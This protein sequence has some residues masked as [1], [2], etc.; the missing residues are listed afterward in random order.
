MRKAL[1]TGITGQDGSYL[2][3]LLLD[4]GY[5]VHGIL[6]RSSVENTERIRHVMS[7]IKLHYGDLT[8]SLSVVRVLS[9]VQPNEIYNLAAQSH[10]HVSFTVPEYTGETDAL[11]T[12]RLLESVRVLG[13][14]KHVRIYQAGTSELFGNSPLSPQNETTPFAPAS[15]Y[16]AAKLYAHEL[17]R[18]YREAFGLFAVNGILFNHESERRGEQF[19]TRKI[20]RA[21][22]RI[23]EGLQETLA[24]G[25]LDSRRD[26]G[27]APDYVECMW[28]MLQ[29]DWP[30][31]YV[32]ATG[33]QH[34]VREFAEKA[35][36]ENGITLEW[37]GSG[38][39]ERGVDA[40]DGMTRVYVDQ[41]F[42][43]PDDV[44]SLL[45][46]PSKA[47]NELGWNS[48]KTSFDT[49]VSVMARHDRA[50]ARKERRDYRHDG[51]RI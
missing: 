23:A 22:G 9:E 15:P 14:E 40:A 24:L 34:S 51:K 18:I 38:A 2:S 30:S 47:V 1:I 7:E 12:L 41:A 31:D 45:G 39:H 50:L 37:E 20:T 4:K 36:A 3:E 33:V 10:V 26:W 48:E 16:A 11:G 46:D 28:R 32:V 19:V 13:M 44:D 49:L 5:E 21:A 42:F 29:N 43:R 8:D 35:F 6:R 17:V 25:N 27:Y